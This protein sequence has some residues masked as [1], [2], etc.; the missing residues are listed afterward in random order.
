M[1][2]NQ[3]PEKFMKDWFR[4]GGIGVEMLASV[5]IGALGGYGLDVLLNTRPWLMIVGFVLG[6]AAGFRSI[7]RLINQDKEEKD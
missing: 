4:Y 3:K 7:F 2:Q 1:P 6:S 5:L